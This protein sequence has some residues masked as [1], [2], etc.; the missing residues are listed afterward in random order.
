MILESHLLQ[1]SCCITW[2]CDRSAGQKQRRLWSA[3]SRFAC[4]CCAVKPAAL[5]A[6]S[7][8]PLRGA[9]IKSE[10]ALAFNIPSDGRMNRASDEVWMCWVCVHVNVDCSLERLCCLPFKR[11]A[12]FCLTSQ[13]LVRLFMRT[14]HVR[15]I[16]NGV[17]HTGKLTQIRVFDSYFASLMIF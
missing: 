3:M 9:F 4:I 10:A 8:W 7:C 14:N 2:S 12:D 6:S 13:Q 16:V 1:K 15:M 5:I 11:I 17:V